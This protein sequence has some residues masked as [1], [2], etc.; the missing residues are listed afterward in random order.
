MTG[1][2]EQTDHADDLKYPNWQR[3]VQEALI[4]LD[5]HKLHARIAE[6]EHAITRR[7]ED[8]SQ[9]PADRAE[10]DAMQHA[11]ASLR[12]VKKESVNFSD[13]E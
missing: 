10:Q 6:A 13:S 9:S 2:S 5:K 1:L 7:L 12:V 4:E 3:P 11:L 8:I